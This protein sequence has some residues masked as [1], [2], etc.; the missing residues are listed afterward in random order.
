MTQCIHL[1]HLKVKTEESENPHTANKRT[2]STMLQI[3]ERLSFW[4]NELKEHR[5]SVPL[6]GNYISV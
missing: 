3:I 1:G 2:S 6:V 4:N 5:H